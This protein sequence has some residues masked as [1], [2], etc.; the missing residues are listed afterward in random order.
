[1]AAADD[2]R[3]MLATSADTFVAGAVSSPCF[4]STP[5][6]EVMMDAFGGSKQI[7]RRTYALVCTDDFPALSEDDQVTVNG[8]VH[9]VLATRR[10]H[11]G[12]M[13]EVNLKLGV[14]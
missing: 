7:V 14:A 9:T 3:A 6:E 10:I 12:H 5:D 11:D 4:L 8:D 1:M 2:I 13:L